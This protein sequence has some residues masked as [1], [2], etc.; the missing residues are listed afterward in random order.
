MQVENCNQA[1]ALGKKLGLSLPGLGGRDIADA[2]NKLI[3]GKQARTLLFAV[4]LNR[5]SSVCPPQSVPLGFVWQLMRQQVINMLKELGGGHAPKDSDVLEWANK[6]VSAAGKPY[7]I[8]S[9][10]DPSISTGCVHAESLS[11]CY[12]W[13]PRPLDSSHSQRLPP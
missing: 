12:L 3:L 4:D 11:Q 9:F 2:N 5:P 7:R 1:V 13:C 8:T 6:A 10:K